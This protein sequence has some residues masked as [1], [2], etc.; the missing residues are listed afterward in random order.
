MAEQGISIG[1]A[2]APGAVPL[3]GTW[4]PHTPARSG[5][6]DFL[7][8]RWT[9]RHRKRRER[10][11]GSTEWAEFDGTCAAWAV[12][13]GDGNVDDHFLDDPAGAYRA[14]TFRQRDVISGLWSIWWFDPRFPVLDPPVHGGFSNGVGTFLADDQLRGRPIRVRFIWS[15]ITETTAHWEQAFSPDDGA[16]WETNWLMTFNRVA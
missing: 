1:A 2:D 9:V 6:F 16:S 7:H 3:E 8:G 14:A 12:L 15:G 13:G 10:L 11:T 5:D 4:A